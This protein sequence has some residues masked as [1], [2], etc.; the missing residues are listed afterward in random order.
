[1]SVSK[2]PA[3]RAL[4]P[5]PAA[6]DS[7][8]PP[9]PSPDQ[10]ATP[11]RTLG[12]EE[13]LHGLGWLSSPRLPEE[14]ADR[15]TN[16]VCRLLG[17]PVAIVSFVSGERQF[18]KGQCGLREPA[19]EARE[20]PLAR[21]FCRHIVASR[22][23]LAIEDVRTHP[24]VKENE[25][26]SD[27]GVGAY[28]GV[29]LRS[30]RGYVLGA[31]AAVDSEPHAWGADDLRV[32]G[33]LAAT[34]ESELGL[35]AEVTERART[36]AVLRAS[37]Q[38]Y[39]TL[40]E[41]ANDAILVLDPATGVILAAN[42]RA[43]EMYGLPVQALLGVSLKVL[44]ADP[45]RGERKVEE[46]LAGQP[47]VRLES[48]HWRSDGAL[49]D[50]LMSASLTE[51]D[52]RL[53]VL[54]ISRDVSRERQTSAALQRSEKRYREIVESVHEVIG[55]T[56][57]RGRWTF[58]NPAWEALTGLSVAESLGQD[59]ITFVH[60]E[61]RAA[62]AA[63]LARLHA[64][65][66]ESVRFEARTRTAGGGYRWVEAHVQLRYD[67]DG[68]VAGLSG[69]LSD[70]SATKRFEAERAAREAAERAQAEAESLLRLK[71]SLLQNMSHELRTPLTGI[72][73]F[74]EVL[75]EEV[76]PAHAEMVDII[77]RSA[78]HLM[79]TLNSVL[80]LAQIESGNLALRPERLDVGSIAGEV[81]ELLQPSAAK[82]GLVLRLDA[83]PEAHAQT[84][85]AMLYR[86]LTNL[87]GNAVKFTER[88]EVV[89]G[90]EREGD[91]VVLRVRDTGMG[92]DPAFLD[93]LF[94]AFR[95]ESGGF[96]RRHEGSGLGLAITRRLVAMMGGT[97]GV[98]SAK[99][100]GSVFTVR[101][102]SS[103][104]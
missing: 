36:E 49:I 68:E 28:L 9:G 53:A 7:G 58:L 104:A 31:L 32:L 79:G 94:E 86:V 17:V 61:D 89:V 95:Q 2:D 52:G 11:S 90:V 65:E 38:S 99:D 23:P 102:P 85:A 69:I 78:R 73:G 27:A 45:E 80:D 4:L 16:L 3:P 66:A 18:F 81:V 91:A 88:G 76:D 96:S 71:E 15:L 82:K 10:P 77:Y 5:A 51:F 25:A 43:G 70:L 41:A 14:A 29:P 8:R 67:E 103:D 74:A 13:Q 47:Q 22:A 54:S 34:V 98:E 92:I 46:M 50:V 64:G 37:E 55:Q 30:P 48:R 35:R 39:R 20:A 84:D 63:H 87:V 101:L 93:Q 97:I 21:A 72:L 42:E 60:P 44:S 24:L 40:F 100:V 33:D 59:S 26:V 1:M 75:A 6:S 83:D 12:E 56:D 19:A 57:A 62:A